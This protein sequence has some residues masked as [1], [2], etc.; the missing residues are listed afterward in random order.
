[1]YA[2]FSP[3]EYHQGLIPPSVVLPQ[4]VGE[5]HPSTVM[6]VRQ[7]GSCQFGGLSTTQ[8]VAGPWRVRD[9]N[10]YADGLFCLSW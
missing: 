9:G 10:A 6:A 7:L 8:R 1:M 3:V 2:V 5:V 4:A